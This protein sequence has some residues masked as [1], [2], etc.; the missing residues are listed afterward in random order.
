VPPSK[1][2]RIKEASERYR[3]F[4]G[5]ESK[6]MDSLQNK[7][8]DVCFRVGECDGILYTT[9]RD[10]IKE[11]YIHKFKKRSRPHLAVSFDGKQLFILGGGYRF[12]ERGI[13]D[14]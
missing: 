9:V 8:Y 4:T 2:A 12:T 6:F 5:H 10:G 7:E 1:Y 3:E 11:S 14:N 13:E